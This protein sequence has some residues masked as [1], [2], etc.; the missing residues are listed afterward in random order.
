M[1]YA[2]TKALVAVMDEDC[3]EA[4]RIVD[5]FLYGEKVVFRAQL[6]KLQRMMTDPFGNIRE[7]IT[8]DEL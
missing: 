2:E 3:D 1:E 8:A 5:G 6:D 4:Q 7:T